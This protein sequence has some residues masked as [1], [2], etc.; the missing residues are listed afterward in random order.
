MDSNNPQNREICPVCGVSITEDGQVNFANGSPGT[1]AR[2]YA[3]VCHYAQKPG[4]INQK[5]QLLGEIT[6]ADGFE[7]GEDLVMPVAFSSTTG[8]TN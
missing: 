2:L 3:R 8:A 6:R 5:P 4:C 1:R 7:S